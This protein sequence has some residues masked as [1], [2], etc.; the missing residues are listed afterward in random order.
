MP[1]TVDAVFFDMLHLSFCFC[2]GFCRYITWLRLVKNLTPRR[3]SI[4][5]WITRVRGP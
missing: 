3:N 2:G 4:V 1:K 5:W